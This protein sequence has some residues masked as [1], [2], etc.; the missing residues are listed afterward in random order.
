MTNRRALIWA[1]LL[2]ALVFM[3]VGYSDMSLWFLPVVAYV[4]IW[5]PQVRRKMT[6]PRQSV[7]VAGA[8]TAAMITAIAIQIFVWGN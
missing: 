3:T 1:F 4:A 2:V 8:F 5:V 6:T 7:Y